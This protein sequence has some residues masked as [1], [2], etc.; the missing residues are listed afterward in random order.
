MSTTLVRAE[1]SCDELAYE[2]QHR[3]DSRVR[4]RIPDAVEDPVLL[5]AVAE[6]ARRHP[7]VEG[8]RANR[9]GQ[10]LVITFHRGIDGQQVSAG[11]SEIC[12]RGA[13]VQASRPLQ[14]PVARRR[15]KALSV[16]TAGLAILAGPLRVAIP[17]PLLAVAVAAGT[18]P[19]ARRALHSLR[20]DRRVNIDVLDLLAIVLTASRGS[21]LPSATMI[22]LVE[23]GEAIRERTA[24]ASRQETLDLLN[25]GAEFVW[26]EEIGGERRQVPLEE[27][28][29][30][31][32]VVVYPGDRIPVDGRVLDGTAL[33]DES[34]LT[35]EPMPVPRGEGQLVYA[36]TLLR[37][38]HIH[39][40][41]EHVG[42]ETRAGQIMRLLRDAP[43]HDTRIESYAAQ[44]ANRAVLPAML[45][46]GVVLILTRDP[47]RAASILITDLTTGV[48]VSVPTTILAAVTT[49]A[50]RGTLI[51][52][53]RALEKL[54]SIDTMIFDKTGTLTEGRPVVTG[55]ETLDGGPSEDDLLQVVLTAEQRLTHPV[56]EAVVEY[57]RR[58]GARPLT[59][60]RWHYEI[61][62]GVQ[63]EI[64]GR[65]VLAG[66]E[67]FMARGNVDLSRFPPQR[68][69]IGGDDTWIYVARDGELIGAL[70]YA[71]RIRPEAAAVVEALKG[72]G[73]QI[74]ML[75]GDRR[76]AALPVAGALG[77][78][79]ED[80][81]AELFPEDKAE[82]IRSLTAAG[83]RVAFVGD[84]IN[85]LPAIAYADVSVSFAGA[86]DVARE[87]ADIVLTED[88]LTGLPTA[89][90][91][92]QRSMHIVRQNIGIIAVPNIGALAMAASIGLNPVAAAVIHNGS[93]VV[94]SVNGLRPLLH[95][96]SPP[97]TSEESHE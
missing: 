66:S 40:A 17:P 8:V 56:A 78:P 13:V 67:R 22:S 42:E 19:I 53:G 71:D 51:R 35:G 18:L 26:L 63:A 93:T 83:R 77:I 54:A 95:R 44:V 29:R 91:I 75:T 82:V 16:G 96:Q 23:I 80:V 37:D 61:G 57:A 88:T 41:V 62:M 85:D 20:E 58:A 65:R 36:S 69:A 14:Q 60:R 48:R 55:V 7:V 28:R 74:H 97:T 31:D 30:G 84:G 33:V 4:I 89:I 68:R 43:V 47:A 12:V 94:A 9:T 27:V 2:V 25:S 32:T 92:A 76:R 50:R 86:S 24:R 46:A 38:G 87:T 79:T 15:R 49:A 6:Q 64:D 3:V 59:R 1:E 70:R 21:F 11:L 34:Q 73:I 81:H 10:W 90:E 45:L 72:A 39:I 52:S 5:D